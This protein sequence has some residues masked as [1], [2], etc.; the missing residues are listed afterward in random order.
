MQKT[1]DI[2]TLIS[3]GANLEIKSGGR[4]VDDLIEIATAA[5]KHSVR[6]TID[7][8]KSLE[9]LIDIVEAGGGAITIRVE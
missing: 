1:N 8:N 3:R 9:D 4:S 5:A 7:A 6:L 2:I